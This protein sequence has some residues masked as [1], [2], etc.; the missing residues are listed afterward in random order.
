MF[1]LRNKV[2]NSKFSNFEEVSR[3]NKHGNVSKHKC[4]SGGANSEEWKAVGQGK[5]ASK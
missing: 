2:Q 4:R 5:L 1:V 3:T